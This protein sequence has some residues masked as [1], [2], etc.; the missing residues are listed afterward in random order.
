MKNIKVYSTPTCPYCNMLKEWL[1]S[2]KIKFEDLNVAVD[3]K[4][5]EE[6]IKKTGQMGVPV[7]EIDGQFVIGYDPNTLEKLMK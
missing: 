4:A 5:A 3:Q 1:H 7:T 2:K 6:I